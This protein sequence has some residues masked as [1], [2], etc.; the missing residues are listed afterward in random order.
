MAQ[1]IK[2]TTTNLIILKEI[3]LAAL[4]ND[5]LGVTF[6]S[7]AG[8]EIND[9]KDKDGNTALLLLAKSYATHELYRNATL[10][11]IKQFGANPLLRNSE[12]RNAL[13]LI[14]TKETINYLKAEYFLYRCEKRF[15]KPTSEDLDFYFKNTRMPK[16]ILD[17]LL[18][19]LKKE[20]KSSPT[21]I[22]FWHKSDEFRPLKVL[23]SQINTHRKDLTKISAILDIFCEVYKDDVDQ[24]IVDEIRIFFPIPQP[25]VTISIQDTKPQYVS[26]A[27]REEKD[28]ART[29]LFK[30]E[31]ET[32]E[33]T[34]PT[35]KQVDKTT[36]SSFFNKTTTPTQLRRKAQYRSPCTYNSPKSEHIAINT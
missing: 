25:E 10:F 6:R 19:T 34:T 23:I 9:I 33:Q 32:I 15:S 35:K 36:L 13:D 24:N 16:N 30:T 27:F 11:L 12:G 4:E 2:K 1:E 18:S 8:K 21:S 7:N 28:T 3:C 26:F 29:D 22:S 31:N 20:G 14:K 5:E 17:G